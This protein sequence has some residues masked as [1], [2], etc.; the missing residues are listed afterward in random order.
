LCVVAV[1][2]VARPAQVCEVGELL[3]RHGDDGTRQIASAVNGFGVPDVPRR[4]AIG[5]RLHELSPFSAAK[6]TAMLAYDYPLLGIFWSLALLFMFVMVGFVVIYTF[7]DNFRRTD[8]GGLAK[9]GWALLIIVV[10]L[11]GALVYILS[12]PEMRSSPP[13][14]AV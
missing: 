13:R 10:P 8:H 6:E 9:A 11:L 4:A 14:P 7:I 5:S 12:R 1:D 2:A 3:R